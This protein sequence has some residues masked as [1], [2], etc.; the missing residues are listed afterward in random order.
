MGDPGVPYYPQGTGTLDVSGGTFFGNQTDEEGGA[1]S[2]GYSLYANVPIDIV[3]VTFTSNS[4]NGSLTTNDPGVQGAGG[5]IYQGAIDPTQCEGDNCTTDDSLIVPS[6]I[7]NSTFTSNAADYVSGGLTTGGGA[8]YARSGI[9]ITGNTFSQN[10]ANGS[11]PSGQNQP[12][13]GIATLD[14]RSRYGQ[15]DAAPEEEPRRCR[16][17]RAG[18]PDGS[19]AT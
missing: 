1:I 10:T 2:A 5:A 14:D 11:A 8:V 16:A 3:G 12:D 6:Y 18:R 17:S 7:E 19:S 9:T 4:A 15:L 13:Y